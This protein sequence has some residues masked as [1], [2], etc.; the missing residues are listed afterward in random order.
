MSGGG[1]REGGGGGAGMGGGEGLVMT[2]G[3]SQCLCWGIRFFAA[4][5]MTKLDICGR[6]HP[7][8]GHLPP[9]GR[10][11]RFFDRL[12]MT[13]GGAENDRWVRLPRTGYAAILTDVVD[14]EI[15]IGLEVHAQL[16]TGSKMFCSCSADYASAPPKP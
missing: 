1:G 15:I 4:L 10:G 12:R 9:K 6:F 3:S 5:R 13:G 11:E 8:P 14:Y 16:L 7:Q 2:G